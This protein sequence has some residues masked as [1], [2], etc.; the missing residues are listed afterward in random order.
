MISSF[1]K[2]YQ[3]QH[4]FVIQQENKTTRKFDKVNFEKDHPDIFEKLSEELIK[5]NFAIKK[6]LKNKKSEQVKKLEE[7]IEG[8]KLIK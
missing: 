2:K 3:F 8:Q 4:A 5:P 7:I 1:L 6:E